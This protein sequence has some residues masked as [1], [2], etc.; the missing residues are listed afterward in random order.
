MRFLLRTPGLTLECLQLTAGMG[1]VDGLPPVAPDG[2]INAGVFFFIARSAMW[3][4][5]PL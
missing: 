5:A 3:Q 1:W 4:A 2:S